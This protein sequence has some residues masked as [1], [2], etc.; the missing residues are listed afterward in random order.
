MLNDGPSRKEY[1]QA[2]LGPA[3]WAIVN[4][5]KPGSKVLEV[6]CA[7]GHVT[8][9]LK[10]EMGCRV[11]AVEIDAAQARDAEPFADRLIVGDIECPEVWNELERDY[12]A[13]VFA[14]VL[15]HLRDPWQALRRSNDVLKNDGRVLASIPN[16][17]Y[18]RVRLQLMLGQFEYSDFGILD[19]THLRFF[20]ANTT[21]R[22]FECSGWRVGK[23]IRIFRNTRIGILN[24]VFPN[25]MAYQF[26]V[27]AAK[28]TQNA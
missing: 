9:H 21:R 1:R 12:D 8:Q 24:S 17:A 25:A 6:G 2:E 14:D 23:F 11:T 26:V 7:T 13:V 27:E 19:N 20:E 22:L 10:K 15:E 28:E 3:H 16:I 4:L 5:L 18:Y